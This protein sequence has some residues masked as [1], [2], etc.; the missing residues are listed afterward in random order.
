MLSLNKII[1]EGY[2]LLAVPTDCKIL[3]V[4]YHEVLSEISITYEYTDNRSYATR[5]PY[6]ASEI[7]SITYSSIALKVHENN[8][9]QL[10]GKERYLTTIRIIGRELL[11]VTWEPH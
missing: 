11:T 6:K 8:T 7:D 3:E 1:A 2:V 9:I 4:K 5:I 10:Q